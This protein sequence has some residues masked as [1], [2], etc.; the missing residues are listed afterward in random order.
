[1]MKN[2]YRDKPLNVISL[3]QS[4]TSASD[5]PVNG[6]CDL[7]TE[8]FGSQEMLMQNYQQL[9]AANR[10]SRQGKYGDKNDLEKA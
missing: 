5:V 2:Q 7:I 9:I 6:T 8:D 3:K 1:M 4:I 10:I